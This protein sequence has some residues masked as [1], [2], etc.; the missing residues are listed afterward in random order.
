MTQA[1]RRLP[2]RAA[3]TLTKPGMHSDG[4]GLYLRVTKAGSRQWV[5]VYQWRGKRR[6]F[7]L[8]G[9]TKVS[10]AKARER[11]QA[12]RD[13][14]ADL[15]DPIAEKAIARAL[16]TFGEL[17]DEWIAEREASV[18]NDKSVARW[19]R[20]LAAGG[21]ADALRPLRID[22]VTTEHVLN[23]LKPVWAKGPTATLARGYIESVL[24]A[25]AAR[26]LRKG[27]NPARW[28]GH[29]EHLL[30]KPTK[31]T[32][33]HHA[34][35]PY[36]EVPAFVADLRGRKGLPARCLEFTIL[37]AARIGEVLGAT[38]G[39]IDLEA[40]LWSIPAERMK[41]GKPHVVPLSERAVAILTD[42]R[43]NE[44]DPAALVFANGGVGL[45]NMATSMMLR[46]M[47]VKVTVHGFRS[48]FRDWA[49]DCTDYPR[50]LLETAL[51]HSLGGVEAAYRR[52]SALE[53]RRALMTDWAGW[54]AGAPAAAN[55]ETPGAAGD[56]VQQS[57]A[58]S[59]L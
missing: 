12:A 29:L 3:D 52:A 48:S 43:P 57:K 27:E 44:P 38:W 24:D 49:G 26:K 45:S 56:A 23:A 14:L 41:S 55:D 5:F 15:K 10:L 19:K 36:A 6:E 59:A 21:I 40:K 4:G 11:A 31:L 30:A 47:K 42:L 17:S 50:D 25:G 34:A 22:D 2:T 1:I 32:R 46:R 16:P 35:L 7:G 33:G 54:C 37:T 28:K 18:R 9:A 13:L 53:K 8:G 20:T 58:G 51:A 39:E